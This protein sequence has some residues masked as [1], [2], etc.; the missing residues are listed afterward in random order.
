ME[1]PEPTG[2]NRNPDGTFKEGVSGNPAGRP[3]GTVSVMTRIRQIFKEEPELFELY[4]RDI[5]KDEKMRREVTQQLDGK[6]VQPIAGVTGQ[7]LIVQVVQYG[8]SQPP[9]QTP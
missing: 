7:P 3:T 9:V 2:S 4:V 8:D 1:L 5:L 6:P